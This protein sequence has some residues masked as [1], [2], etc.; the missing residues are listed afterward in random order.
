MRRNAEVDNVPW[1]MK[2]LT[3]DK[4]TNS[5]SLC[6]WRKCWNI[7]R[8]VFSVVTPDAENDTQTPLGVDEML[9]I[10]TRLDKLNAKNWTDEG[11]SIWTW[12]EQ[13]QNIK[14][15]AKMLRRAAKLKKRF[16]HTE[17]YFY[18]SW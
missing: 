1:V 11:T 13:R 9:E 12:D 6:Y 3:P 16:P 4:Y 15:C 7:R 14:K 17:I 8:M 2:K 18:D 5:Y 10:A